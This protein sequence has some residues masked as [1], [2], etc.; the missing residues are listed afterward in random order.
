MDIKVSV[1]VS[2]YKVESYLQACIDS[3]LAQTH[4]NLEVILVDDG[5]PD[6]CPK[7]CDEYADKDHRVTVIHKLN[8]GLTSARKAGGSRA[9]GEYVLYVD[10]DDWIDKDYV[11]RMLAP[12]EQGR[13]DAVVNIA[14][15]MNYEDG[16]QLER[17]TPMSKGIYREDRIV[18]E[19]YPNYICEDRFYDTSLS[20]NLCLY[21]FKRDFLL[22]I[23]MQ[24]EDEIAM[25]EDM[26]LTFRVFL[27]AESVAV[28]AHF[29]Y[30]YRQRSDSM[31]HKR[32]GDHFQRI[33]ILYRNL[34]AAVRD[35]HNAVRATAMASK[36]PRGIFFTLWTAAPVRFASISADFLFPF[37]EVTAGSRVFVYGMGVVGRGIMEAIV[38]SGKY[39]LVGCSDQGW[40]K[41]SS[42]FDMGNGKICRVYAP[43]DLKNCDFDYVI[44]GVSRHGFR[45]QITEHLHGLGVP[46][47]KIARLDQSLLIEENLPF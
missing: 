16:R 23:Q 7:I 19:V 41:Y 11:E 45:Q 42:G 37:P 20:T 35:C 26:A 5:S 14:T 13:L 28:V 1:V 43:E 24:V 21:L 46:Y 6:L 47:G 17:V 12:L 4:D 8:G 38:E 32:V 25:G 22:D 30:H 9:V 44:I 40:R 27:K 36:I 33:N 39:E 31:L 2:I 34:K 29:G 10:G 18:R 3:I 15:Y